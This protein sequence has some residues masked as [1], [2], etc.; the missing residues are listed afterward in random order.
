MK[1]TSLSCYNKCEMRNSR[2]RLPVLA[3]ILCLAITFFY[4]QSSFGQD[5]SSTMQATKYKNVKW[6][7]IAQVDFKPGK[8]DEAM[9]LVKKYFMPAGKAAGNPGPVMVLENQTGSWDIT[10]IWL[11][12]DGPSDL[13]WK[14]SPENVASNAELLKLAGSKEKVEKIR[15]EWLSDIARSTYNVALQEDIMVGGTK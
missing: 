7:G 6:Y 14:V 2:K 3:T 10:V 9:G 4:C 12:K 5:S 15:E 13:E 8:M 11:L 1:Y